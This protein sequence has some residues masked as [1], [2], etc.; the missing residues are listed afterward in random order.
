MDAM[1]EFFFFLLSYQEE[2]QLVKYYF[3]GISIS[4]NIKLKK[5]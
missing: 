4:V 2:F 3:S 1:Y 5:L